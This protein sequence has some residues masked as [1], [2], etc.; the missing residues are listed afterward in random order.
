MSAGEVRNTSG[1]RPNLTFRLQPLEATLPRRRGAR[2]SCGDFE[3]GE[4]GNPGLC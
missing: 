4:E 1:M 2:D 3:A